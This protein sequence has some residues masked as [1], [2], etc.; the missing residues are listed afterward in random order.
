ME[1]PRRD[2]QIFGIGCFQDD[3]A[4]WAQDALDL[5]EQRCQSIV[6]QVLNDMEGCYETEGIITASAQVVE[7]IGQGNIKSPASCDLNH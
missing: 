1:R 3:E 6:R 7:R 5:H 2:S 4:A